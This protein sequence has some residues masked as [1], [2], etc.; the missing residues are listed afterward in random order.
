MSS[1]SRLTKHASRREM[2]T[3]G[4][5][6]T[7]Q[8]RLASGF[9]NPMPVAEPITSSRQHRHLGQIA[10][11]QPSVNLTSEP[12]CDPDMQLHDIRR[13]YILL[14]LRKKCSDLSMCDAYAREG[15]LS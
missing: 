2:C 6:R 3:V 11:F 10:G 9:V 5:L 8:T 4:C 14:R 15:Q 13:L 12:W 1:E 7:D